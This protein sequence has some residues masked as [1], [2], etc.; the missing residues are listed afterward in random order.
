M[1]WMTVLTQ[2]LEVYFFG[3]LV[4]GFN[5]L[6]YILKKESIFSELCLNS[7]RSVRNIFSTEIRLTILYFKSSKMSHS[8]FF[9]FLPFINL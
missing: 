7:S 5:T 9:I 8:N 2:V 6:V 3:G 1:R 4:F